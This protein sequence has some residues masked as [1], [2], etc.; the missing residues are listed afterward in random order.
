MVNALLDIATYG[1]LL[2]LNDGA[3]NGAVSILYLPIVYAALTLTQNKAWLI[4][5]VALI[6]YSW[7]IFSNQGHAHHM[8][9]AFA[10]HMTG[11]WLTF[12]I[13]AGLITWFVTNQNKAINRQAKT[14]SDFKERQLRDEQILAVATTAANAAHALST[15]LSTANLLVNELE[16]LCTPN[17]YESDDIADVLAQLDTQLKLLTERVLHIA[18]EAKK[19]SGSQKRLV[20]SSQFIEQICQRWWVSR[21]EI[22]LDIKVSSNLADYEIIDD[23]NLA[24]SISNF[25]ENAAQASLINQNN[26]VL[27]AAKLEQDYLALTIKDK[28]KGI[29]Q[30]LLSRL[31][32]EAV[33]NH[34]TGMGIGLV[35]A[36]AT[37]ER[38]D[39]E[40]SLTNQAEGGTQ[41]RILLPL[42]LLQRAEGTTS[43]GYS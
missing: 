6:C 5:F 19:Q 32:K 29:D 26:Q 14:I 39:G 27:F 18:E 20:P 3:M 30:N 24:L 38:L 13:S 12:V 7:L 23:T 37:L 22:E 2:F 9:Q 43:R 8:G 21:N 1:L 41:C 11:M 31:G 40:I 16:E 33:G 28:G 34:S 4:T 10:E 15:P 25:L 17:S 35:L 42:V 36:N